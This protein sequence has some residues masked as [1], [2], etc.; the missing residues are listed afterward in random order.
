MLTY[1]YNGDDI[2]NESKNGSDTINYLMLVDGYI[3]CD[4]S[5]Y[6]E[7][8]FKDA[9]GD[10]VYAM[11]TN[12]GCLGH[13]RYTAWGESVS[14]YSFYGGIDQV[15][16]RYAGEYYDY[17]SGMT[18]P[19]SRYYDIDIKRFITEDQAK[20]GVNWYVYCGNSPVMRVD[21][22]GK[23]SYPDYWRIKDKYGWGVANK[24]VH[25]ANLALSMAN[26]YA[27]SHGLDYIWN[28]EADVYRHFMWNA[29]LTRQVGYY[30][31]RF[32]TNLHE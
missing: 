17:E 20:D 11:Y 15:S 6:Y 4:R 19:A 28:N 9:H 22:S 8:Y 3:F 18:L 10:G 29:M 7:Y 30:E 26:N 31:A 14:D 21:P 16:I 12:G 2:I 32:I 25:Y 23:E 27:Y 1:Y 13:Y 24:S 5:N